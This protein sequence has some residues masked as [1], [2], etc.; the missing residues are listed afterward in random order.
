MENYVTAGQATDDSIIWSMRFA[1]W[2]TK[3]KD[4]HSEY[5]ILV[6]LPQSRLLGKRTSVLSYTYSCC[7]V[8]RTNQMQ[9][10]WI[11]DDRGHYFY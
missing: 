9:L 4:T 1:W 6:A 11:I 7:L 10:L 8:I 5:V 2:I 3:V